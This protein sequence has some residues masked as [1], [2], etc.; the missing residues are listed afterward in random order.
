MAWTDRAAGAA[1]VALLLAAWEVVGRTKLLGLTFPPLTDVAAFLFDPNRAG[2]FQRAVG[3]TGAAAAAGYVIGALAGAGVAL[4]GHLLRPARA[5]LD[6]L[7]AFVNAIPGIALGPILIVT[8]GRESAPVALAGLHVYFLVYV[9]ATSG[10]AAASSAHHDLFSSL[11]APPTRRF[12]NLELPAALPTVVSA[13]KLS[14]PAALLG[15]ILG[16][17]FGAERGLGVLVVNAMQNFQV[18]L[19]WSAVS[20]AALLS[21]AAYGVLSLLERVVHGR[22]RA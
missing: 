9:A 18:A 10:L 14:A 12:L 1:G 16:E 13:L 8:L 19:L 5:G 22:F 11:G 21:L 4:A 20:L 15:A 7:A 6:R 2:L 3:A 17:W